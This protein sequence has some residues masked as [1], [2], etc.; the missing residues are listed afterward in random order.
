PEARSMGAV[1]MTP[2]LVTTRVGAYQ[3]PFW[4]I[5]AP[6]AFPYAGS[7][8]TLF[9]TGPAGY[10][11][12]VDAANGGGTHDGTNPP[13]VADVPNR[14]GEDPHEAPRRSHCGQL[15][16]SDFLSVGGLLTSPCQ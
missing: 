11:R 5:P 3:D 7:G 2:P 13:P 1:G 14:S 6:P 10:I 12:Q 8:I 15:Q 4:G 9:D 16:K